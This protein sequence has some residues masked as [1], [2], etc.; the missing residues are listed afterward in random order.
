MPPPKSTLTAPFVALSTLVTSVRAP[1]FE[2]PNRYVLRSLPGSP[3]PPLCE[4]HRGSLTWFQAPLVDLI[5]LTPRAR[6]PGLKNP[7][8]SSLGPNLFATLSIVRCGLGLAPGWQSERLDFKRSIRECAPKSGACGAHAKPKT[9]SSR[10]HP[11]PHP[12]TPEFP[13]SSTRCTASRGA[14]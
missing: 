2:T 11:M 9:P 14:A 4:Q 12:P 6:I 7:N 3:P 13:S 5:L 8:W 10:S 1:V